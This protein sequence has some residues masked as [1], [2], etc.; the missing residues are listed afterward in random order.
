MTEL[1]SAMMGGLAPDVSAAVAT[2]LARGRLRLADIRSIRVRMLAAFLEEPTPKQARRIVALERYERPAQ[3]E[4][5]R[6]L[7]ALRA[8]V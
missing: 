4:Q 1:T 5:R 2:D 7:K 6:L 8:D 3:R